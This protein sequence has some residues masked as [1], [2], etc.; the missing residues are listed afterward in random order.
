MEIKLHLRTVLYGGGVLYWVRYP[1]LP[2]GL[3]VNNVDIYEYG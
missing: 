1:R 3:Q 2:D